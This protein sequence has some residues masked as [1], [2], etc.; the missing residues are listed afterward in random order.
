MYT[1]T[2]K[3]FRTYEYIKNVGLILKII[4]NFIM[5]KILAQ[6]IIRSF[7]YFAVF[8]LL[9]LRCNSNVNQSFYSYDFLIAI[10]N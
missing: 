6:I 10:L 4:D 5:K 7:L 9:K 1:P 8:L 3:E 2:S